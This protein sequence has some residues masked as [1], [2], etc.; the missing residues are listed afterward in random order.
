MRNEKYGKKVLL[1]IVHAVMCRFE[2]TDTYYYRDRVKHY[3]CLNVD[4]Q[5]DSSMLAEGTQYFLHNGLVFH[6]M[7]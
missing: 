2:D 5:N 6:D 7:H 4:I 1:K 3:H